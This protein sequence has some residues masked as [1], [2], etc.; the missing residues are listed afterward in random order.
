MAI[1]RACVCNKVRYRD[2]K[3]AVRTLHHMSR[4]RWQAEIDGVPCRR[5][6]VRAYA[7]A[8]CGGFHLTSQAAAR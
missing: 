2:H 1:S 6:E 7:C 4:L 3:E 8:L 5:R